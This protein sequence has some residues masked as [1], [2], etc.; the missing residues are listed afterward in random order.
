MVDSKIK[1]KHTYMSKESPSIRVKIRAIQTIKEKTSVW[2]EIIEHYDERLLNEVILYEQD[3]FLVL[4][5]VY[6]L[7]KQ[8][9]FYSTLQ[10][11]IAANKVK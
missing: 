5:D 4:Y 3:E 11:I 7:K 10:E 9:K 1:Y 6:Q 2:V 8:Q